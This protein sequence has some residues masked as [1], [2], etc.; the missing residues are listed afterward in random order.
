[1]TAPS[2][3]IATTRQLVEQMLATKRQRLW[4][5]W[6]MER[7]NRNNFWVI[8]LLKHHN[9]YRETTKILDQHF[10]RSLAN[11]LRMIKIRERMEL[12]RVKKEENSSS[13][14]SK[15]S[16][17]KKSVDPNDL[18]NYL[19]GA[20]LKFRDNLNNDTDDYYQE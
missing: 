9:K 19:T 4:K 12:E 1:M 6:D 13:S 14:S 17:S 7:Y 10:H 3:Q 15:K 11:N 8:E 18:S 5:P 16:K 20:D 2:D